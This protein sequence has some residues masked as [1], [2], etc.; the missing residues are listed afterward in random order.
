ML[1]NDE[2]E[3]VMD[4]ERERE[5]ESEDDGVVG[6]YGNVIEDMLEGKGRINF[7][8]MRPFSTKVKK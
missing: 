8:T 3:F 7:M 6:V 5:R 2:G 4:E 1:L